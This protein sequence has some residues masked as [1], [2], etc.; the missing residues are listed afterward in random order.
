MLIGCGSL[1]NYQGLYVY[2]NNERHSNFPIK[3]LNLVVDQ[4]FSAGDKKSIGEAVG[5]WNY[6]LNGKIKLEVQRLDF[7]FEVNQLLAAA[8]D[9]SIIVIKVSKE[10]DVVKGCDKFTTVP[11]KTFCL[12]FV[13]EIGGKYLYVVR[14]RIQDED[15]LKVVLH[16][17]GHILGSDHTGSGLM[18]KSY[19]RIEYQCIDLETIKNVA[20]YNQL[21]VE[22]LNYCYFR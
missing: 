4:D 9:K 18:N 22:D 11:G 19:S 3:H 10:D 15:V 2:Q 7:D 13:E 1:P 16:E 12:G 17:L 14:D 8:R 5:Q 20:K 21:N 6:A